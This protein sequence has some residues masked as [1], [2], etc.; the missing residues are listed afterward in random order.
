M[1]KHSP[2]QER[3]EQPAKI[4]PQYCPS[5]VMAF[6]AGAI[7]VWSRSFAIR[8]LSSLYLS[9]L[10]Y[11]L[12]ITFQGPQNKTGNSG[13]LSGFSKT[14]SPDYQSQMNVVQCL[15]VTY[16]TSLHHCRSLFLVQRAP[17]FPIKP[18]SVCS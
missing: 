9:F 16:G 15:T 8:K 1:I 18:G 7:Q 4:V 3:Q 2:L 5:E 12:L 13:Y 6:F 10:C 14:G 11:S 17:F